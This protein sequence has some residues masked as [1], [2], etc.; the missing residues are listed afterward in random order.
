[1]TAERAQ[2]TAWIVGAVGLVLA[3]VGWLL[4]PSVF[5]HA[6]LAALSAWIGWPLGCLALLLVH[7]L[8]GGRW[9]EAIRPQLLAGIG[10]LP[11]LLPALIPLMFVLP[12]LY[13]WL[14]PDDAAY[15]GNRFYLNQPFAIGRTIVYLI[16]WFGFAAAAVLASRF[17]RIPGWIA[18]PGLILLGL[19]A[20]FA[21]IDATMSLDPHFSSSDY[22]MI[23]AA[24]AGLLGLSMCVLFA[25]MGPPLNPELL[26]DLG[27]LLQGLLVLWAYLD[28]MQL[29]IV[30]QADLPHEVPWYNDR[31]SHGWGVV[32]GIVAFGHFLL[33]FFALV[34]PPVR[35]SARAI[36]AV[37]ALLVVMEFLR[38]W[39]VV[40]PARHHGF[41]WIDVAAVL[42]IWGFASAIALRDPMLRLAAPQVSHG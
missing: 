39:W 21:A 2:M 13:P 5:P 15:L 14:R 16:V 10:T 28:F 33:P 19:S 4:E 12:T 38:A 42:A 25:A 27:R 24:E 17:G 23:A 30:W 6:W 41:S 37:A 11:L 22:G 1:M 36:G 31:A 18:V 29:L 34:W 9:G 40:L 26:N 32:A 7:A 35:R 3:L 20:S 8:T